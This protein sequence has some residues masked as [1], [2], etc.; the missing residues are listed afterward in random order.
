MAC[1]GGASSEPDEPDVPVVPEP[2]PEPAPDVPDKPVVLWIDAEANFAR[3]RAKPDIRHYLD[4]AHN[5]G[6]NTLVVDVKPVQGDVLYESDFLPKCT[7]L[8]LATIENRGY[9]YLQ[10]LSMRRASER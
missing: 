3:F 5:A 8:G 4:I 10:F 1:S 6:F 2:E 9:D 7:K